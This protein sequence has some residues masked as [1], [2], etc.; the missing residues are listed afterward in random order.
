MRGR[1]ERERERE[2]EREMLDV[3]SSCFC[4]HGANRHMCISLDSWYLPI[5][6]ICLSSMDSPVQ[7]SQAIILA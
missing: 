1:E 5:S 4:H 7:C 3:F 2:R 6:A